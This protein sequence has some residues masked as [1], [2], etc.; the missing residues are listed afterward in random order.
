MDAWNQ[1]TSSMTTLESRF[2]NRGSRIENE[3]STIMIRGCHL[4]ACEKSFWMQWSGQRINHDPPGNAMPQR[5]GTVPHTE[6]I[7]TKGISSKMPYQAAI[8]QRCPTRNQNQGTACTAPSTCTV[9]VNLNA[10]VTGEFSTSSC[11]WSSQHHC[12]RSSPHSMLATQHLTKGQG[13]PR[14]GSK[15]QSKNTAATEGRS[16][17]L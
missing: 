15:E 1:R 14:K 16:K 3:G 6:P 7:N 17:T 13:A 5:L 2:E 11:K 9:H 8:T 4:S 12:T 10:G